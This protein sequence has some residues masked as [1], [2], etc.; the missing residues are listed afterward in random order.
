M[1]T[2]RKHGRR[3]LYLF[4][5]ALH[6]LH[7]FILCPCI[8][9]PFASC[10]SQHCLYSLQPKQTF[11]FSCDFQIQILFQRTVNTNLARVISSVPCVYHDTALC[12]LHIA[13]VNE[14][15][16]TL[17]CQKDRTHK[18]KPHSQIKGGCLRPLICFLPHVMKFH[19]FGIF[20]NL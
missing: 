6:I 20:T 10:T 14:R 19:H 4:N 1:N 12:L 2:D 13:A 3:F 5:A 15:D 17:Y 7:L 9:Q 8:I 11:N 18:H 16:R